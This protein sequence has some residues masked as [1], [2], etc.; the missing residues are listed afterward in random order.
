MNNTE[1]NSQKSSNDLVPQER[2]DQLTDIAFEN[3]RKSAIAG[4]LQHIL[5]D[6]DDPKKK[7]AQMTKERAEVINCLR[8]ICIEYGDN[9]WPDTLHIRDIIE[10]HLIHY[11]VRHIDA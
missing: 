10:K 11:L 5:P 3:G 6:L 9:D 1:E 2:V 7:I 4:L 8:N